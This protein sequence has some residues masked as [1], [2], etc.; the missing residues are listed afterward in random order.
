MRPHLW[1]VQEDGAGPLLLLLHGAGG[2][3]QSWRNLFPLLVAAGFRVVAVDLPGQGF[4]RSGARHRAGLDPTSVD[5]ARLVAAE[6]WRPAAVIGHSAGAAIALRLQQIDGFAPVPVAVINPALAQ[7]DGVAGW[8]FPKLA[9]ALAV[10]PGVARL[11]S[12]TAATPARV[13]RLLDVTG[14]HVDA[15][16]QRL[17][18]MLVGDRD[19]VDGTLTMMA[20]WSVDALVASLPGIR[21]PVLFVVADS[22]GSVP[23]RVSETAAARMPGS[24]IVRLPGGH[25]VHEE[26]PLPVAAAIVDFL[27][28]SG[29]SP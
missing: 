1:H 14:S 24:G 10:A 12:A 28:R 4:T 26:T 20:Q 22:D 23:P 15:E 13:R 25:L 6:G 9:K 2:A 18:L 8:L 16:G 29:A 7:F 21:V 11:F 5:V 27:A 17:Y 19:H 3:T